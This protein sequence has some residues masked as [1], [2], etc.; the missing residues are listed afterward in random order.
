MQLSTAPGA[1]VRVR[2]VRGARRACRRLVQ[3]GAGDRRLGQQVCHE[4]LGFV[5]SAAIGVRAHRRPG[6][7]ARTARR[8]QRPHKIGARRLLEH[9]RRLGLERLQRLERAP[10]LGHGGAAVAQERLEAAGAVAVADQ[11]HADPGV[12][13]APLLE[14]LDLHAIGARQTP[15]GDR[16]PARQHE[17]QGTF[18][19]QLIQQRRLERLKLDGILVRQHDVLQGAH[20]VLQRILRRPGLAL[21]GLRPAR[22][23]AVLTARLG[24]G[25]GYGNG[26]AQRGAILRHGGIPWLGGA[27]VEVDGGA[28]AGAEKR[29]LSRV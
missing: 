27:G 4:A 25:I 21:L 26:R 23:R 7:L 29:Q 5:R 19:R 14:Q 28:R 9:G 24:A 15:G 8:C 20:A 2:S 12:L 17:L 10:E 6:R 22:L 1:P 16:D 18:R 13:P 3:G 11:R